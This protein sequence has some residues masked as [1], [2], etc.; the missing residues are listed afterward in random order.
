MAGVFGHPL[1]IQPSLRDR[2]LRLLARRDYAEAELRAKLAPHAG[3]DDD[4]A[5]LVGQLA[6]SGFVS[7]T[8]CA[9]QVSR[10]HQGK[11]GPL[12]IQRDLRRRG[13]GPDLIDQHVTAARATEFDEARSIL[14]RKFSQ[15]ATGAAE[16]ARQGRYLEARGFSWSV[17][18][19]VLRTPF[20][21]DESPG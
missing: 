1:S 8:R 14:Q 17:I 9:E 2:A 15:V 7:D 12:M 19:R 21:D 6:A 16:R 18:G 5:A 4:L 3:A 11:H 13:I 10:R 20:D